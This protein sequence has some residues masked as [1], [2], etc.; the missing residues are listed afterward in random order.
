MA[1][2]PA[3]VWLVPPA[4]IRAMPLTV[5]APLRRAQSTSDG[6][7]GVDSAVSCRPSWAQPATARISPMNRA[8]SFMGRLLPLQWTGKVD[9][10]PRRGP[11]IVWW[12]GPPGTPPWRS[13][14]QGASAWLLDRFDGWVAEWFKAP[15]LKT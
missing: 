11:V 6:A 10:N 9:A 2:C 1:D 3:Q 7:I 5:L 15:V 4:L 14:R 8:A 12:F 13:C